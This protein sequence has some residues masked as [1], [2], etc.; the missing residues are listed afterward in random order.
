[1]NSAAGPYVSVI[2]MPTVC[3]ALSAASRVA[4]YAVA[5]CTAGGTEASSPR[6]YW[7]RAIGVADAASD[8]GNPLSV[9]YAAT[10]PA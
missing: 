9:V 8:A 3:G 2:M 7:K 6:V 4:R 10:S 5:P 1:M